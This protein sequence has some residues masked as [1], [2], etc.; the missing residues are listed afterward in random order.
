MTVQNRLP[1]EG[2]Q[3]APE[4]PPIDMGS[5]TTIS[6]HIGAL[7]ARLDLPESMA[8]PGGS[9]RLIDPEFLTDVL[10]NKDSQA[11]RQSV[12]DE[13]MF[14]GVAFNADYQPLLIY[15]SSRL[16]GVVISR[17]RV[18]N[19]RAGNRDHAERNIAGSGVKSIN[20]RVAALEPVRKKLEDEYIVLLAVWKDLQG[21][22][23]G[24]QR[25]KTG[26]LH[27]HL[28][29]TESVMRQSLE[30]AGTVLSWEPEQRQLALDGL[31][32]RLWG[33][34]DN[35]KARLDHWSNYTFMAGK[36]TR[37]QHTGVMKSLSNAQTRTQKNQTDRG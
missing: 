1:F 35:D 20:S 8:I 18:H 31:R 24:H 13:T 17:A 22:R 36:H 21:K 14:D 27:M 33:R 16:E 6:G 29:T 23:R 34:T 25:F 37:A 32:Y 15:S 28:T 2:E 3:V 4:L 19:R 10:I 30:T 11:R 9:E 7:S 12:R 26:N 5:I